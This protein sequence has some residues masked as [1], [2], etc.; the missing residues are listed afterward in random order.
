MPNLSEG[1]PNFADLVLLT[2][3]D[4]MISNLPDELL[5]LEKEHVMVEKFFA[6]V[7]SS[8]VDLEAFILN[9]NTFL[10]GPGALFFFS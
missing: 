7:M 1:Q 2:L 6:S 5:S 4:A 9:E 3:S 10:N 8:L